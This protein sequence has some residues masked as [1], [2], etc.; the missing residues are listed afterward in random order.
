MQH[1]NKQQNTEGK[2]RHFKML[3]HMHKLLQSHRISELE[4]FTENN[5]SC[6]YSV[7]VEKVSLLWVRLDAH[8]HQV[9]VSGSR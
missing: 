6:K 5:I 2:N 7:I 1:C 3:M 4:D 8:F 9:G